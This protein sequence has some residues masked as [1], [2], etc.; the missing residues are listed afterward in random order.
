MGTNWTEKQLQAITARNKSILVSAAAGS[1]KT[2]TLTE[3]IVRKLTDESNPS[4]IDKMLIV[5]FTRLSAA[6]LK[7]K[8]SNAISG[9]LAKNPTSQYL[10]KQ[11][12]LLESANICTIDSFYLDIVR[13]NFQRIGLPSSF[14]LADE[15][16][17]ALLRRE[18]MDEII[19][20]HYDTSAKSDDG[21]LEFVENFTSAKQSDTLSD[22]FLALENKLCSR[23]EGADAILYFANELN[24]EGECDF[25]QSR[26]GKI[27]RDY[28]LNGAKAY[29]KALVRCCDVISA[30]ENAQ[31]AYLAAFSYE[32]D[33]LAEV[34]AILEEG[35][36]SLARSK[37]LSFNKQRLGS[38]K[39]EF[40]TDEVALCKSLR[41]E[42]VKF[43]QS[44]SEKYFS[45]DESEI[46][47]IMHKTSDILISLHNILTEFAKAVLDEKIK[48]KAFAFDDI[49]RFAYQ[50][51]TNADGTPSDIALSYREQFEE[52]YIDEYQDVDAMQDRIFSLIAK[53][54]N[55]FMV[56]D[57]K[58]SIYS[59][60]GA[61]TDVFA[62]YKKSF[63]PFEDSD[64]SNNALIFMSNNFR[65]DEN[66]VKFTNKVFSFLFGNCGDSIEYTPDDD[67]IF[68]KTEEGRTLPSPAVHVAV[69]TGD[70]S[71]RE[72]EEA[73]E[74]D[75]KSDIN[76]E[77][78]WIAK[79][80]KRL[81]S[82]E[83]K[84]DGTKIEPRDIAVLMRATT[85]AGDI[86]RALELYKI[87]CSD[88]SK[89]D[90]FET[91]DVLLTLSLLSTIDNPH[92]DIPLAAT[93][94]SPIFAY[95][96]DELI[97]IR[98]SA[99][100]RASL[101]EALRDYEGENAEIKA[102]NQYFIEKLTNYR[103]LSSSGSIDKLL[104][105]L[106]RDLSM[107]TLDGANQQ[108]LTRLYEMARK[109][110]AGSFK[111]LNNFISYINELIENEKVP[112][113]SYEDADSNAVQMITAHK[114]KGLEFPVCF[115]CN[116]QS[117]F[118]L[119]DTKP[120]LLY[121]SR[122][123]I[124][125]KLALEG[126][127]AR[128]NTPLREAVSLEISNAQLEE[129]MRILYVALTRARERLYVTAHTRSR[130]EKLEEGAL[131]TKKF[132]SDFKVKRN[133][134]WLSMILASI[135]P[136][137]D[138]ESYT[139]NAI[140]RDGV[141]FDY[142]EEK[143]ENPDEQM[144]ITLT[145]EQVQAI[146]D[147]L[148]FEY[149]HAHL[150]KLPAKLS[151]SKLT[152]TV[153]DDIDNDAATLES[154]DEAKILEI[155]EFFE[156]KSKTTSADKGTATHL[157]LQFC[158]FENADKN[159][160]KEELSRLVEQK[161]IAPQV[162]ELINLKQI[163][164]FFESKFYATLKN[165]KTT[166][167]EQRFNILLPAS[168]FTQDSKFKAEIEEE[169][170]LIQGVIDLFFED[171]NGNII[172]CDYKTD[173]LTPEELRDEA[174]VVKKMK[175][176]HGRQLEYYAMAIERFLGKAPDKILIY[177]LPFGEAVEIPI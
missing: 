141:D 134:N 76:P 150:S 71:A 47:K 58:Q 128:L 85:P 124:A 45:F 6:D 123:G 121:H 16:E 126:G 91:P 70:E 43:I 158:D 127:M 8:I 129:E 55:R 125:L 38:L 89:Y 7:R 44:I 137:K 24:R 63:A 35:N 111:G 143:F 146:K 26:Q 166:Y 69:I 164:K 147:R 142:I 56:G 131:S 82:N 152:P 42:E 115:I 61:D 27:I 77:A 74:D 165:A 138:G 93:L 92:R 20:K 72:D 176:R 81:I 135:Y 23:V 100:P 59:F 12:V 50:L 103:A 149:P 28:L 98:T 41:D 148:A 78:L 75:E 106:Y 151:V 173:Y 169:E 60:R 109:F 177:S 79:E 3:R 64:S 2:A 86:S 140:E 88:N 102:K 122:A 97:E 29:H 83:I 90:L 18:V 65:C 37:V 105:H 17:M 155:E 62:G 13:R 96:M 156:S 161:F 112:S 53:E 95:T 49:R 117:R 144:S 101:F 30:E 119:D 14:R 171:G 36:Y 104:N 4:S 132:A 118:N 153:L 113:L 175:D 116:T 114:S 48:R 33:F 145:D 66:V 160:A 19:E 34:S 25:F 168:H 120:N 163:E 107:T 39:K 68:S 80:I 40:K 32:K 133:K 73:L 67:L 11:L 94:Y 157:F 162:A 52:I 51:L 15:G 54:N 174:L 172:L 9:E 31:K 139:F 57:I 108:N 170:I 136:L 87:P 84:A 99:D 5:T 159:G 46:K 10:S 1:G 110:E 22:I 130:L 21:F 167:R 154:F